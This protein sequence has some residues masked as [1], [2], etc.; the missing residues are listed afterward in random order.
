MLSKKVAGIQNYHWWK[1]GQKVN[2]GLAI[3][4]I[5][6]DEEEVMSAVEKMIL[7]YREQEIQANVWLIL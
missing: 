6:K 2:K 7:I 4:K 3:N 5:F 1:M